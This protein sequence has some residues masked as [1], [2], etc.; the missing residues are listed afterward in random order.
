MPSPFSLSQ[1]KRMLF[2]LD[3]FIKYR[4][5]WEAPFEASQEGIS[6]SLDILLN[7]V[8]RTL[9]SLSGEG[10]I[11]ERLA[12][13]RGAERRRTAYF[14]SERGIALLGELKNGLNGEKV[15]FTDINGQRVERTLEELV[16]LIMKD[17][18]ISIAF[19]E[20]LEF[21]K[22]RE[23][24]ALPELVNHV[25]SKTV[26]GKRVVARIEKAPALRQFYG[27]ESELKEIKSCIDSGTYPIIIIQGL[28]GIGKSTLAVKIIES[29]RASKNIFWYRFHE[30]NSVGS[31]LQELSEFLYSIGRTRTVNYLKKNRIPEL[32]MLAGSLE[33]DLDDTE[34]ILVFDDIHKTGEQLKPLLSIITEICDR[35]S[36]VHFVFLTRE[37]VKFYDSRE[38]VIKKKIKV[39][40]L[41]GLDEESSRKMLDFITDELVLKD[42]LELTGGHPLFLELV[43]LTGTAVGRKDI[44]DFINEEIFSKLS[45]SDRAI[46]EKVSVYRYPVLVDAVALPGEGYESLTAMAR[47]GLIRELHDRRFELHDVL[48]DFVYKRIPDSDRE[49]H[50]KSAARYYREKEADVEGTGIEEVYH[51]QKSGMWREAAAVA[52]EKCPT[53]IGMNYQ[54][55]NEILCNFKPQHVPKEQWADILFLKAEF[56]MFNEEWYLALNNYM[57]CLHAGESMGSGP[58]LLASIHNAIAE[59]QAKIE[60]WEET[61]S[62]QERALELFEKSGDRL[63]AAKA[64]INLGMAYRKNREFENAR[65]Y[66]NKALKI[67]DDIGEKRGKAAVLNNI[68][69]LCLDRGD[70]AK[71][72]ENIRKSLE[73]SISEKDTSGQAIAHRNLG[74]VYSFRGSWE[75]AFANFELSFGLFKKDGNRKSAAEVAEKAGD[76]H[77]E[78]EEYG[79]ALEWYSNG[80]ALA[81]ETRVPGGRS[82]FGNYPKDNGLPQQESRSLAR[83]HGKSA[84][85][86]RRKKNPERCRESRRNALDILK[87]GGKTAD[88]AREY[89]EQALDSESF[90][91]IDEGIES[92]NLALEMLK[93]DGIHRGQVAANLSLGRLFEEKKDLA[94]AAEKY[95]QALAIA[96]SASDW[97]G[98]ANSSERLALIYARSDEKKA[99]GMKKKAVAYYRNAGMAQDSKRVDREL[100]L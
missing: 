14:P 94:R 76:Q 38:S 63:G 18:G 74:E 52:I 58:E 35:I 40:A 80:I 39:I 29:Y 42:I 48:R 91:Q 2:Y 31:V 3:Q 4:D 11:E 10:L 50:H 72:V 28:A 24:F 64:S 100:V 68:G 90:G 59:V 95:S 60:N 37:A 8:S 53:L 85:I 25:K 33:A 93:K 83:L 7:N 69:F 5:A 43:N 67:L 51:L 27:R 92:L 62:S 17:H 99:R 34:T 20:I 21:L 6:Q 41:G 32:N 16:A 23:N 66:Y 81:G 87:K 45:T 78:A 30:W 61:K 77:A 19:F 73:I 47:K 65:K 22:E 9:S 12:H 98:A 57:E 26:P 96:E 88:V 75:E 71:A 84:G 82:F 44:D 89:L 46:I 36:R 1:D 55:L 56:H 79:E 86:W 15:A 13:M 97:L 54:E 49:E 70:W